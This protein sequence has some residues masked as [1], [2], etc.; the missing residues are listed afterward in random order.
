VAGLNKNL[1]L[2]AD[3]IGLGRV[4]AVS[5][6]DN[7]GVLVCSGNIT[8]EADGDS[9]LSANT[10]WGTTNVWGASAPTYFNA[11]QVP[12]TARGTIQIMGD[13]KKTAGS[14]ATLTLKAK[15]AIVMPNTSNVATSPAGSIVSTSG[16]LNVLMNADSDAVN[17]GNV[18]MLERSVLTTNGGT[19]TVGGGATPLTTPVTGIVGTTNT[20]PGI[21][22]RSSTITTG[23]GDVNLRSQGAA[24]SGGFG[25]VMNVAAS[26]VGCVINSGAGNV[27][28]N[29]T[30]GAV[31]SFH[32]ISFIGNNTGTLTSR[33][34]SSSG[35]I[36][37]TGTGSASGSFGI[38]MGTLSEVSSTSG[39]VSMTAASDT[40]T[41][42]VI[43]NPT[44]PGSATISAGTSV[45]LVADSANLVF[46]TGPKSITA[47]SGSGIINL[48]HRTPVYQFLLGTIDAP[49]SAVGYSDD[50]LDTLSAATVNIG[51]S[52]TSSILVSGVISPASYQTLALAQNT[53]FGSSSGFASDVT[54]AT[55][56]EKI[57]VA[58][59]VN[60][61]T[62]A[63]FSA[64]S[65]GGYVWNGTDTFT[66]LAND[67]ADAI[68]GTVAPV[69]LP[70]LLGTNSSGILRY[71]VGTN[72]NDITIG[73][74]SIIEGWRQSYFGSTENVGL[75]ANTADGDSDGKSNLL[76]FA[77]G[78][79][80]TN[81]ASG[82]GDLSYIGTLAGN[83]A[84]GANGQPTTV[85]E[86]TA[87]N[88]DFRAIFVR[89]KDYVAAG[90]TYTPQFSVDLQSW[91]NSTAIPTVLADDG[92]W[93]I[94]SVPYTR[95]IGG[96]KARFF[97]ITVSIAP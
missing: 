69:V 65:T 55:V 38:N 73:A 82:P 19:W 12:Y 56:F 52:G 46:G 95:S 78:T 29:A 93:Q 3:F 63:T 81:L 71:N 75:S 23:G 86:P 8:L 41:M 30:G 2:K 62:G 45:T 16:K 1:S 88:V 20:S 4:N 7:P 43:I 74:M 28:V 57:T 76:E 14:D 61:S 39:A 25:L 90:L 85:F 49:G 35:S 47:G 97:Q 48:R 27:T 68:T 54:S 9:S 67:G 37:L 31:S 15:N 21:F 10:L 50:E 84:I 34:L 18:V 59:T 60:I 53:S 70:N 94:V 89:R 66:L 51:D 72:A 64:A 79:I 91:Q 44:A 92:T 33:I 24:A 83:G 17:A 80:P 96:R 87:D 58:G 26:T 22:L 13:I 32:G 5:P 42:A 40:N 36:S 11:G 6:A 77:F